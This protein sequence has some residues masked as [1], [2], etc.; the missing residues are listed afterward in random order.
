MVEKGRIGERR[1]S[2]IEKVFEACLR[3]K[4]GRRRQDGGGSEREKYEKCCY[5]ALFEK[6]LLEHNCTN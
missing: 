4:H 1:Q 5:V 6:I 2:L 3:R